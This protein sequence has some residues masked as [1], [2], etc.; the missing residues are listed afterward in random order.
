MDAEVNFNSKA[1]TTIFV[2]IAILVIAVIILFVLFF[3]GGEPDVDIKPEENPS[4]FL[5]TCIKDRV[6]EGIDI[7]SLQGG[8]IEPELYRTFY[9]EDEEPQNVAYLCY[10]ENYYLPC[11]NQ[12]PTLFNHLEKEI[13]YYIKDDVKDCFSSLGDSL[14]SQGYTVNARYNGFDVDIRKENTI[15]L[16]DGELILTKSGETTREGLFRARIPNRLGKIAKVV[17]EILSQEARFC[18]FSNLG[19]MITWPEWKINSFTTSEGA[20]IYTVENKE[21]GESFRFAIRTCVLPPGA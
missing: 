17:Q 15:I 3:Q 5:E 7:L 12:V 4:S 16:I 21:S 19:Y 10:Q 8:Y 13:G 20:K 14:E 1:Q 9:F 18:S 6:L 11:V 2:I